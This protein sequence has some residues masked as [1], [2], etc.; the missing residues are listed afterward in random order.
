VL[1]GGENPQST[2]REPV[3]MNDAWVLDLT[4]DVWIPLTPGETGPQPKINQQAV[5]DS[6][7]DSVIVYGGI[8]QDEHSVPHDVWELRV[9]AGE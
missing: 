5:Y 7:T 1:E 6:D 9:G 3:Y 2:S 4:A 8:P